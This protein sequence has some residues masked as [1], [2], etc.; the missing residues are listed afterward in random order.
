MRL[1][2]VHEGTIQHGRINLCRS[3]V[4]MPQQFLDGCDVD[5]LI[6]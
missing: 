3:H 6:Y 5:A 1:Q 2:V 4:F